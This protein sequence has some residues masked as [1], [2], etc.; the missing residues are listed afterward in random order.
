MINNDIKKAYFHELRK[1]RRAEADF[2]ESFPNGVEAGNV[3]S[4]AQ[5]AKMRH[6]EGAI[7]V[8]YQ[9]LSPRIGAVITKERT[10]EIIEAYENAT[11]DAE[12]DKALNEFYRLYKVR[13]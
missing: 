10:C 11:S 2:W 7:S 1:Y 6:A 12:V 8:F 4:I 9:F 5:Y 13:E 3:T